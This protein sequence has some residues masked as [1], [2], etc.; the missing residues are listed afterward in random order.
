MVAR[1]AWRASRI[2][3]A[4]FA[5][6]TSMAL[7]APSASAGWLWPDSP[8]A[9]PYDRGQFFQRQLPPSVIANML[10]SRYGMAR[11]MS[12]RPRGDV[13]WA[14]AID[15]RGYRVRFTID[16]FNGQVLESFVVGTSPY[17]AAVPIP[18]G[19]V[20]RQ[21]RR[22][23]FFE[24]EPAPPPSN[25]RA[26][27]PRDERELDPATPA[28]RPDKKKP[29]KTQAARQPPTAPLQAPSPAPKPDEKRPETAARPPAP[30]DLPAAPDK[31]EIAPPA[32]TPEPVKPAES[33]APVEP[34]KPVEKPAETRPAEPAR[35]AEARPAEPVKPAE[36]EPP[37]PERPAAR[38]EAAGTGST[39]IPEPL[40]DPK[41]GRRNPSAIEVPPAPLDDAPSKKAEPSVLPPPV[42][43]E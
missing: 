40:I 4:F 27:I 36:A 14:D 26:M 17:E 18:P 5:A 35:P 9:R 42:S 39:R 34:V 31:P 3:L 30:A 6:S 33:V 8:Y 25:R 43:L 7:W 22:E 20:P 38:A 10:Y 2:S 32:P 1:R 15:R 13:Y 37:K 16:G 29:P 12:V 28:K 41:T 24:Q 19:A 23:D 21:A 11:V